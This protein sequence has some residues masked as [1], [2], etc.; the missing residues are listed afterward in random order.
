MLQQPKLRDWVHMRALSL[1]C[2]VFFLCVF[3]SPLLPRFRLAF[4][5]Q[6]SLHFWR[7]GS[8]ARGSTISTNWQCAGPTAG[9][10]TGSELE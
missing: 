3:W 2:C 7:C 1:R 5:S 8:W 9:V 10:K 4:F 6:E